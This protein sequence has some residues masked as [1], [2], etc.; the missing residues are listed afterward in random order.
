M[1]GIGTRRTLCFVVFRATHFMS[2]REVALQRRGNLPEGT[3]CKSDGAMLLTQRCC[4]WRDVA[5]S[6]LSVIEQ[7][8]AATNPYFVRNSRMIMKKIIY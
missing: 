4:R 1:F 7:S 2:L 6:T 3:P 5:Y 8:N